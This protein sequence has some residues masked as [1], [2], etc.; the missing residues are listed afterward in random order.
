MTSPGGWG[1]STRG[2]RLHALTGLRWW[3]ALGVFF[4]HMRNL[5]PLPGTFDAFGFG[6]FGV[7]FFFILSGFVLTWSAAPTTRTSTFYV[8]RFARIW[9][10]AFV[11]LLLAIP[12]FYSFH[13]NPAQTYVKP[14][15]IGILALSVPLIQGWWRDPVV[16][17]SGNPAAWTLTLEFFFYA[18]HPFINRVLRAFS[19]RATVRLIVV[20]VALSLAYRATAMAVPG[21]FLTAL[22]TPVLRLN[23][24]V[25]GMCVAHAS[26]LGWRTRLPAW[27]AI[28]GLVAIVAGDRYAR[29][30][31]FP[32]GLGHS[33]IQYENEMLLI[34]FTALI[35]AVASRELRGR[36]SIFGARPIVVL[37]E[38]SFAF[39]LVHATVMYALITLFGRQRVS[40]DNVVWYVPALGLALLLTAAVH[41]WVEKPFERR[42]RTA[43]ARH[44]ARDAA[45][46]SEPTKSPEAQAD[47]ASVG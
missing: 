27:A 26:R 35:A 13:P 2:R 40:W 30:G 29:R 19:V 45:D 5:A 16:L 4:A 9:P 33:F 44:L 28:A 8:N 14:V 43:W 7:M 17:F 38:W 47:P 11:T 6:A 34:G 42:I 10:A 20:I 15:N 18:L 23:E 3:A 21:F 32:T 41:L 31:V 24:F 37:G 46:A 25:L 22:P 1:W 39:Y 36:Y 12:V